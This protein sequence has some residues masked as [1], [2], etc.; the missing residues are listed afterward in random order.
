MTYRQMT[1]TEDFKETPLFNF[2]GQINNDLC[3]SSSEDEKTKETFPDEFE[4]YFNTESEFLACINT[5]DENSEFKRKSIDTLRVEVQNNSFAISM[6]DEFEYERT[7]PLRSC[8]IP[9]L[10]ERAEGLTRRITDILS[11]A[12]CASIINNLYQKL[13]KKQKEILIKIEDEAISAIHSDEYKILPLNELF[14]RL[15][16]YL[17]THYKDYEFKTGYYTYELVSA[18]YQITDETLVR[19][20]EMACFKNNIQYGDLKIGLRFTSSDTGISGANLFPMLISGK[21]VIPIWG[22]I[23][24]YHKGDV[25]IE[26]FSEN[27]GKLFIRYKKAVTKL[28]ELMTVYII[29]PIDCM[30]AISKK[31]AIGKKVISPAIEIF[32]IDNG[33]EPCSAHKIYTAMCRCLDDKKLTGSK[34]LL[35]EEKLSKA[36]VLDWKKYDH[37]INYSEW[38]E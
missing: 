30:T 13:G 29:N 18:F 2:T 11:N 28:S 34:R 7:I 17:Y 24:L 9:T 22:S 3:N 10:I 26:V 32:S 31:I 16:T 37:P 5:Q 19:E 25:D 20:Y 23:P 14:T 33:H 1:L 8:A 36:L 27:M 4:K 38:I 35:V 12:E 15:H 21:N 6:H